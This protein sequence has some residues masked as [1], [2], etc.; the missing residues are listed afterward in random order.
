MGLGF[1]LGLG[2]GLGLGFGWAEGAKLRRIRAESGKS[3]GLGW[4]WW[5]ALGFGRACGVVYS[6]TKARKR[7]TSSAVEPRGISLLRVSAMCTGA[8]W[9]KMW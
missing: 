2:L 3:W 6:R 4:G 7:R 8:P 5:W 1:A 9:E